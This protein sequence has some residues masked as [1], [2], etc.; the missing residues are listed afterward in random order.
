MFLSFPAGCTS[1]S[2]KSSVM[3]PTSPAQTVFLFC[4]V[5]TLFFHFYG[6]QTV[7]CY[8]PEFYVYRHKINDFLLKSLK[9]LSIIWY[10]P[11]MWLRQNNIWRVYSMTQR[12]LCAIA[13]I[14]IINPT[15]LISCFS[16][17]LYWTLI[18]K[19]MWLCRKPNLDVNVFKPALQSLSPR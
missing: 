8:S 12:T 10:T 16:G 6:N 3:C 4:F 15:Y 14:T 11:Y 2:D 13:N 17:V 5:L 7:T 9:H 19:S 1:M 18:F